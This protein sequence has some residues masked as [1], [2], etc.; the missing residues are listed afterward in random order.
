MKFTYRAV[1]SGSLNGQNVLVE[2]LGAFEHADGLVI[3]NYDFH[4]LPV[5]V[6]KFLFNSVMITGYPSVCKAYGDHSNPFFPGSYKYEREI[7]FGSH[8]SISYEATCN[9]IRTSEDVVELDSKFV[10]SGKVDVPD[11]LETSS[12]IETWVPVRKNQIEGSFLV[13]WKTADGS[14]LTG[15][16]HSQYYLLGEGMKSPECVLHRRIHLT[17]SLSAS[18]RL[19]LYQ[20]SQL[21]SDPH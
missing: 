17:S 4:A 1:T 5:G 15:R 12:I 8:G 9:E 11:L 13:A 14:F 3:G 6:H 16:A 10:L 2:G 19:H 20:Q 21:C 7:D 18:G